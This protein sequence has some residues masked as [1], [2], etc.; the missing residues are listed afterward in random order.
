ML[1]F[2]TYRG[3]LFGG[4]AVVLII[5]IICFLLLP[6]R[7]LVELLEKRFK[8]NSSSDDRFL[9]NFSGVEIDFQSSRRFRYS[10]IV[11]LALVTWINL[12]IFL[13]GCLLQVQHYSLDDLCPK[14]KSDCFQ[15]GNPSF[16]QR[17][18]CQSGER[19]SNVTGSTSVICFSWIYSE[20]NAVSVLN[21]IG[22]CSSVF[23]LF[24]HGVIAFCR[25]SQ[26]FWGLSLIIFLTFGSLTIFILSQVIELKISMTAKLLLLG[27][28]ALSLNII[29]LFQFTYR[30]KKDK[31]KM[32]FQK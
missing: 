4:A 29:Q 13:D 23:S 19:F 27:T 16:H 30:R 24:C 14:V 26:K 10:L 8:I 20:I 17:I 31:N 28:C 5:E 32:I 12:L 21:Q 11:Q 2:E 9:M 1:D 6:D 3:I 25:L 7:L 18:E 22:I 15:L